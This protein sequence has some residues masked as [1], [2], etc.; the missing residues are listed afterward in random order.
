MS[1]DTYRVKVLR[2]AG[3]EVTFEIKPTTA[4]GLADLAVTRS[5]IAMLFY[6]VGGPNLFDQL[7]NSAWAAENLDKYVESVRVVSIIGRRSEDSLRHTAEHYCIPIRHLQPRTTLVAEMATEELA[8]HFSAGDSF[9]TTAFD[10]WWDDPKRPEIPRDWVEAEKFDPDPG[11]AQRLVPLVRERLVHWLPE[12]S[13]SIA[14]PG[15][16]ALRL[17]VSISMPY[18]S[19]LPREFFTVGVRLHCGDL[20]RLYDKAKFGPDD[21]ILMGGIA[22]HP[23]DVWCRTCDIWEDPSTVI[24]ESDESVADRIVQELSREGVREL[25]TREG[26]ARRVESVCAGLVKRFGVRSFS[27]LRTLGSGQELERWN[28]YS[29]DSDIFWK[30]IAVFAAFGDDKAAEEAAKQA[31]GKWKKPPKWILSQL[32]RLGVAPG[33]K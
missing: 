30:R 9:G 25:A 8:S 15:E 14:L 31:C 1:S 12:G 6:D 4:G 24:K 27:P 10:V 19:G 17:C 29:R 28:F 20:V 26:A 13:D 3:R 16:G 2:V 21:L 7:N 32:A 33:K 18:G 22:S 5:F 23:Y 11:I